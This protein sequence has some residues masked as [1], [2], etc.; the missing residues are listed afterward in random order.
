MVENLKFQQVV[1]IATLV[2]GIAT[3]PWFGRS[4]TFQESTA[5]FA[6]ML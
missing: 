5:A 4:W 1:D 3:D 6:T 2:Q